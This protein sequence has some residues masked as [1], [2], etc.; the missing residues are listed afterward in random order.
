LKRAKVQPQSTFAKNWA[1]K[2]RCLAG[3]SNKYWPISF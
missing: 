2:K 3:T 1:K